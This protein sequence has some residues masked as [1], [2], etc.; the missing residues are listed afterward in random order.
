MAKHAQPIFTP[1]WWKAAGVRALRTALVVA[2]PYLPASLTDTV[3]YVAIAS[4]AVMGGVLSLLTSLAGL[5]ETTDT[6]VNYWVAIFERVVKTV[7]QAL[8]TALGTTVFI[9]QVNFSDVLAIVASSALGSLF[10]AVISSLP[11]ASV[12]AASPVE[13]GDA[14]LQAPI[15]NSVTIIPSADA[16]RD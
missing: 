5:A 7:A 15:V 11:E 1:T 8:V 6:Q 14:D 10:L 13:S 9:S 4:A 2:L 16:R 12:P 3:P